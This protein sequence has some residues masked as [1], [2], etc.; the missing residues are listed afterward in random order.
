MLE[1]MN[2]L[3]SETPDEDRFFP[4]PLA[5]FA[6]RDMYVTALRDSEV[7]YQGEWAIREG[8][9]LLVREFWFG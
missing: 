4:P 8:V 1:S 3:P 5:T 6:R 9:G 2:V 7:V